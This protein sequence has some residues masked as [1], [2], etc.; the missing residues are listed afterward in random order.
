MQSSHCDFLFYGEQNLSRRKLWFFW[1]T[2]HMY[3]HQIRSSAR[4]LGLA[5]RNFIKTRVLDFPE[6]ARLDYGHW[7]V[8]SMRA[9]L[10][11]E[12]EHLQIPVKRARRFMVQA[13]NRFYGTYR[14][15][16]PTRVTV[17][18]AV[19]TFRTG[20]QELY[21]NSFE[22]SECLRPE[23][24]CSRRSQRHAVYPRP[25]RANWSC[26]L[27]SIFQKNFDRWRFVFF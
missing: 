14:D 4:L 25:D 7:T 11:P 24:I 23:Y 18:W 20:F 6:T 13:Q 26:C 1:A 3:S 27:T 9:H 17:G 15:G 19:L 2:L 12:S 22:M 8:L 16:K 10:H 21:W 5:Y